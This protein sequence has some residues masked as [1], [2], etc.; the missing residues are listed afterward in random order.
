M[1]FRPMPIGTGPRADRAQQAG[2]NNMN[3]NR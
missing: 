3:I 1:M 2:R